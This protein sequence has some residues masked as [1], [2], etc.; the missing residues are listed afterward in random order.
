[1]DKMG[2]SQKAGNKGVPGTPRDGASIEITGLLKSALRWVSE[3]WDKK[4]WKWEG[5]T[6]K[7][8]ILHLLC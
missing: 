2:E 5:V 3:L 7:G 8:S 6:I 1:M 4:I